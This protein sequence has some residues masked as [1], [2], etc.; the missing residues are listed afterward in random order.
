[1]QLDVSEASRVLVVAG[2]EYNGSDRSANVVLADVSDERMIASLGV[3]LAAQP[4]D[5]A[6]MTPGD[7]TIVILNGSEVLHIVHV[8]GATFVR[9]ATIWSGD[10]QLVQPDA[11][12]DWMRLAVDHA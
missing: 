2:S 9:C 10:A 1:M 11:L 3:A 12:G 4:T 8:V 7:P 5:A 6:L